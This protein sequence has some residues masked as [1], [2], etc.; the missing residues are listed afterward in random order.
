MIAGSLAR[1]GVW[2]GR[3]IPGVAGENPLGF[4][5][6]GV[7]REGIIKQL[8][9]QLNCDPAGV[10]R[11]PPTNLA[12][13]APGLADVF[14]HAIFDDGYRDDRPWLYKDAKLTLIWPLIAAAFPRASWVIVSRDPQGIIESCLRTGFMRQHSSDPAFWQKL[15]VEYTM[16]LDRLRLSGNRVLEICP[17]G[18]I[19]G[20]LAPLCRLCEDLG[21]VFD[22]TRVAEFVTPRFWHVG[23]APAPR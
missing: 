12:I 10:T 2:T 20:N 3:T 9:R 21:L 8:L 18:A 19:Q 5:E 13:N 15:V 7:I 17:E 22:K 23:A 6:H 14:R 4:F 16:R 11:L 1:C